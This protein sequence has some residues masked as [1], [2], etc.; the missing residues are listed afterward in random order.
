MSPNPTSEFKQIIEQQSEKILNPIERTKVTQDLSENVILTT[1]DDLY[2]WARCQ[3]FADA[4]RYS[5][6]FYRV[7]SLDW[8]PF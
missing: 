7:R 6:L 5:L 3:V 2:N 1:V 4:I 8:F